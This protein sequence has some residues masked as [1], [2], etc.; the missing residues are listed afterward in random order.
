[1]TAVGGSIESISL[2]GRNFAVTADAEAQRKVG[3]FENEVAAN[4]DG[5]ARLIKTQVPW[6]LDGVAIEIDDSR[7]DQ[8]FLQNIA[9]GNNF[10]SVAISLASGAVWQGTGQL[11]GEMQTSSQ[12][13][14]MPLAI[15]G[16]GKLTKQA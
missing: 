3:G 2:D 9:D 12:N 7:N 15:M 8:Q 5:S 11:T 10:V 6:S 4:G 1:M 16:T 14:S 13:A